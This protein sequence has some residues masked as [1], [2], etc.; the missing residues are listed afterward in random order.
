MNANST[1]AP[2]SSIVSSD[3]VVVGAV[4]DTMV[5]EDEQQT[6]VIDEKFKDEMFHKFYEL[7]TFQGSKLSGNVWRL[8][9]MPLPNK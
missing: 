6:K 9:K 8:K 1:C 4:Q 2:E 7:R 5:E 3:A